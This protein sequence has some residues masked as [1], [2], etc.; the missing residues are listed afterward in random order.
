MDSDPDLGTR[1]VSGG[2]RAEHG[3]RLG[4]AARFPKPGLVVPLSRGRL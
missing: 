4:M 3:G 1:L 2:V